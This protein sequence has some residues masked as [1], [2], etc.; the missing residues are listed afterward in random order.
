MNERR[1]SHIADYNEA[2]SQS[3]IAEPLER[4]RFFCSLAMNQHDWLDSEQFFDDIRAVLKQKMCAGCDMILLPTLNKQV[5]SDKIA[6]AEREYATLLNQNIALGE[7]YEDLRRD[8]D[9]LA[10]KLKGGR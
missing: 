5:W 2:V 6:I 8:R 10:K 1:K 4:L 3:P 7:A 9:R